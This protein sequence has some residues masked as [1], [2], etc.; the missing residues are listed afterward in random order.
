MTR[1][2]RLGVTS[3]ND[4]SCERI[5]ILKILF[6]EQ[7][8][9]TPFSPNKYVYAGNFL[10]LILQRVFL[11]NFSNVEFFYYRKGKCIYEAILRS[12]KI[13]L[14]FFKKIWMSNSG[15]WKYY[16][17]EFSSNFD[18]I[19]SQLHILA[20][21][22]ESLVII[23]D[24]EELISL[25]IQD[26]FTLLQRINNNFQIRGKVDLV[27]FSELGGLRIIEYKTGTPKEVDENQ[28][29]LY[30]EILNKSFP[31]QS[32]FLEL[33]YSKPEFDEIKT[34]T[35]DSKLNLL[36]RISE[37]HSKSREISDIKELPRQNFTSKTC[38]YCKLCELSDL[39]RF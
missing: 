3:V 1:S 21:L 33:W 16:R 34:I 20:K 8:I 22:A 14:D 9:K 31:N 19:T 30:G 26:E 36:D 35:Q 6:A 38:Q 11:K 23:D 24:N 10:H 4:F 2:I 17:H 39:L 32:I 29:K 25:V 27:A 15:P 28:I 5:T 37:L 13:E 18:I 12:M 7:N